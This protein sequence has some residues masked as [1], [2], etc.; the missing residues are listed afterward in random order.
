MIEY[1]ETHSP[2]DTEAAGAYLAKLLTQRRPDRRWF[3]CLEG[4]LGAG[5][6]AFVR[7][8]ASIVSPGSRVKSPTYTI[9]HEYRGGGVPLF[10]FDL[11]RLEE[12]EDGLEEI[13]FD[14]YVAGGHC[15]VEW[16]EYLMERPED[17]ITV[18]IRKN[19]A[20]D[21]QIEMEWDG[22]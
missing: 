3:I 12:S 6:T 11:Y 13:G 20:C 10:H 5:K 17:V 22:C 21:R 9:V 8:F 1:M 2:A 15:I 16:S 18:T 7:G 19:G 14:D 4:D